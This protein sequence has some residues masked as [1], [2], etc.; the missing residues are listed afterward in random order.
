MISVQG[1]PAY[2]GLGANLG[3]REANI[4][5][6]LRNLDHLPTIQV[7][8]VSSLYETAPVGITDQPD[9]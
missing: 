8:A 9:F 6:A 4:R 2:L 3:N 7:T 5:E 1:V